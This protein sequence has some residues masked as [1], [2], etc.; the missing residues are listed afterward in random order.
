MP[1]HFPRVGGFFVTLAGLV[2]GKFMIWDVWMAA[3]AGADSIS[4]HMKGVVLAIVL[5]EFGVLT[6]LTGG[7]LQNIMTAPGTGKLSPLGWL[8]TI[9]SLISAFAGYW[10]FEKQLTW[11]GYQF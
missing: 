11:L 3:K 5:T 6:M 2:F 4:I 7:S 9:V 10:Y 1:Q 8:I